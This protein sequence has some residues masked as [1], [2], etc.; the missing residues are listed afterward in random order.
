MLLQIF[1]LLLGLA[2]LYFGAEAMVKGASQLAL[3]LG[4]SPMIV[5]LTVVGFGTSAPE[6]L[7]SFLAALNGASGI[8]VGNIVGSNTCNIALILG[9]AAVIS[10]MAI[11]ASALRREYPIMLGAS[12]ALYAVSFDAH[13]ARWEGWLLFTGIIAFIAYNVRAARQDHD[14]ADLR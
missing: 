13:I 12:L 5:G 6:L 10:P 9:V 14:N 7:V 11:S 8:S 2:I 1:L 4:I 3:D